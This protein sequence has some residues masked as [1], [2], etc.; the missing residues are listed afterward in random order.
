MIVAV[1]TVLL[2]DRFHVF[3]P[4]FAYLTATAVQ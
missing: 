2:E 1:D 4:I 3:P